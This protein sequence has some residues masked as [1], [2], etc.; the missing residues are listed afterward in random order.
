MTTTLETRIRY[1]DGQP[2]PDG[3]T[4]IIRG[5]RVSYRV[6]IHDVQG[7]ADWIEGASMEEAIEEYRA[8]L[9][10]AEGPEYATA[11]DIRCSR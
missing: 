6:W 8:G 5:S 9:A 7:T 2:A 4:E 3:T 1:E 11:A 10:D